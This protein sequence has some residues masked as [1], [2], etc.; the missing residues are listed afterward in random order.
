MLKIEKLQVSYDRNIVLKD[1]DLTM[2]E[3]EV[4]AIL[5]PNGAG[6][7]TLLKA[8]FGILKPDSGEIIWRNKKIS[9]KNTDEILRSGI[10]MVPQGRYIFPTLTVRENL[11]MGAYIV[12]SR[13]VVNKRIDNVY[14]LFSELKKLE[15][16]SAGNLSGGE[17]QMLAI[18]RGLMLKPHL[19]LVD[20]PSLGL[21]PIVIE[22]VFSKLNEINQTGTSLLIVEQNMKKAL[23]ISNKVCFLDCG[24]TKFMGKTDEFISNDEVA[25]EILSFRLNMG[26]NGNNKL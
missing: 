5:G 8:I 14:S 10:V 18:A 23:E 26:G 6:K 19:L 24:A 22:K 7:S 21:A 15:K 2:E 9:G 16:K 17:Q 1:F 3:G 13:E 12:K 4:I 25:Q 20:E 11:Q